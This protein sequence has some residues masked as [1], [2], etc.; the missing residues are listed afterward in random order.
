MRGGLRRSR[1]YCIIRK[2]GAKK[3][4]NRKWG[5]S[6]VLRFY[7][8]SLLLSSHSACAGRLCEGDEGKEYFYSGCRTGVL[9]V[10]FFS[11]S[12]PASDLSGNQL[13]TGTSCHAGKEGCGFPGCRS[14]YRPAGRV[15]VFRSLASGRYGG[16]DAASGSGAGDAGGALRGDAA[17]ALPMEESHTPTQ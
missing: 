2:K 5:D 17:G 15:P 9:C 13:G 6:L 7:C 14:Q 12:D 8:F 16:R 3:S 1:D 10:W 11:C 4:R